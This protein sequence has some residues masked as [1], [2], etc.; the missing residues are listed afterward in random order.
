MFILPT[1]G[2]EPAYAPHFGSG[3]DTYIYGSYFGHPVSLFFITI[4]IILITSVIYRDLMTHMASHTA[5]MKA[6]VIIIKAI[7]KRRTLT[8][9]LMVDTEFILIEN[10]ARMCSKFLKIQRM[11]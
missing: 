2:F 6:E 11:L 1:V 9:T 7:I 3:Y 10:T 4:L 8:P 5:I